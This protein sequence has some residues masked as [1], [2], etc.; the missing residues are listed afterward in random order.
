MCPL[1][2]ATR[3]RPLFRARDLLYGSP[4]LYEV[5]RCEECRLR[6]THP[7]PKDLES[8][9]PEEYGPHAAPN[10]RPLNRFLKR[11][12][13]MRSTLVPDLPAGS[14]ILEIGCGAGAFLDSI[15]DRGWERH[16]LEP[17]PAAAARARKSG[18][19][20]FE[21]ALGKNGWPDG[22]FSAIFAWMAIEH[23][24][25]LKEDLREIGRLLEPGGWLGFSV[26]NADSW[27]FSY[28]RQNWY[29]LHV[30]AHVSHFGGRD[31]HRVLA[32]GGLRMSR[33]EHQRNVLSIIGS[34]GLEW[35]WKSLVKYPDRPSRIGQALLYP[36]ACV[37]AAFRQ[38][39]R[40]TALARKERA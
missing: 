2:H 26:P 8:V 25:R 38:G 10:V 13:E 18:A 1:C 37:L 36:L 3:N 31:L 32:G 12:F 33:L 22:H 40:V 14:R 30:P 16:G 24:P 4:G 6:Y 20:I 39:G 29:A 34:L 7:L 11:I 15:G 28:F 23:L 5:V 9:Y 19:E 35:G 27:E 21:G 17:V